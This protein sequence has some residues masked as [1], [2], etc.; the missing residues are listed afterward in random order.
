M[1]YVAQIFIE[2]THDVKRILHVGSSWGSTGV[3]TSNSLTALDGTN[4]VIGFEK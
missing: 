1:G 2:Y 3:E 4:A